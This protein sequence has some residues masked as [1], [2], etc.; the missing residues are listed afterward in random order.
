MSSSQPLLGS[1]P[2]TADPKPLFAQL[3]TPT[4]DQ[5]VLEDEPHY[6]QR[7][8]IPSPCDPYQSTHPPTRNP[9]ANELAYLS[10]DLSLPPPRAPSAA[11]Q[12][13]GRHAPSPTSNL[14]VQ[15]PKGHLAI[16]PS[17]TSPFADVS[18]PSPV[19]AWSP[20][21]RRAFSSMSAAGEK[22]WSEY[23]EK[24][25]GALRKRSDDG[26]AIF[27]NRFSVSRTSPLPSC[28]FAICLPQIRPIEKLTNER[29]YPPLTPSPAPGL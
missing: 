12:H 20:D 21:E 2:Q 14:T 13:P 5:F 29:F 23:G 10:D 1:T 7:R 22:G 24:K 25:N 28:P 9:S 26:E 27:W 8:C 18:P 3:Q 17:F 19:L 4:S 16:T 6:T 11:H 15:I